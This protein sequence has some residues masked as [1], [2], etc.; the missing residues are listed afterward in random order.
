MDSTP[1]LLNFH[2]GLAV[3][4]YPDSAAIL[5]TAR[6]CGDRQSSR[7]ALSTV[8]PLGQLRGRETP[9]TAFSPK[10]PSLGLSG[11]RIHPKVFGLW[12]LSPKG[13]ATH[14]ALQSFRFSSVRRTAHQFHRLSITLS[15]KN[16]AEAVVSTAFDRQNTTRFHVRSP[17]ETS[18]GHHGHGPTNHNPTMTGVGL[19]SQNLK[20]DTPHL[21]FD[22]TGLACARETCYSL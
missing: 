5:Y 13:E 20:L 16:R 17:A 22:I 14:D 12:H 7:Q 9:T 15:H 3:S 10:P 2:W 21:S 19:W 18:Y 6:I 8:Y 11:F 4:Q 1:G